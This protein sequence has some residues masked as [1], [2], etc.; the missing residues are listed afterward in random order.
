MKE[1]TLEVKPM[2]ESKSYR[3]ILD[4]SP[5]SSEQ[6]DKLGKFLHIKKRTQIIRLALGFLKEY[7]EHAEKGYVLQLEKDGKI[8]QILIPQAF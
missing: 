4:L 8:I 6:V 2:Q 1:K 3:V 7:V 5:V